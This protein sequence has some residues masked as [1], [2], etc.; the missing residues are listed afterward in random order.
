MTVKHIDLRSILDQKFGAGG[1]MRQNFHQNEGSKPSK[2]KEFPAGP[3]STVSL[4]HDVY[5][6]LP[7][8]CP[9]VKSGAMRQEGQ[10]KRKEKKRLGWMN[11]KMS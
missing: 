4:L 10:K 3:R 8:W 9:G 7:Q 1:H 6:S 5:V 11:G 2:V